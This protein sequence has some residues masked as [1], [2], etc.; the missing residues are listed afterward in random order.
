MASPRRKGGGCTPALHRLKACKMHDGGAKSV[1]SWQNE[2]P[3]TFDRAACEAAHT[4]L[5]DQVTTLL[6][7]LSQCSFE[8]QLTMTLLACH[9]H[10]ACTIQ[11]TQD[12]KLML[13]AES[14]DGVSWTPRN[15]A[16]ENC[17]APNCV[18][19]DG[20]NEF[21]VVYDDVGRSSPCHLLRTLD[22]SRSSRP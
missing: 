14:P 12:T 18:T 5:C 4:D 22:V 10:V 20:G 15:A 3:T 21:G 17:P 13:I 16:R 9:M 1:A 2:Q 19:N 11:C 6:A 8:A 7:F